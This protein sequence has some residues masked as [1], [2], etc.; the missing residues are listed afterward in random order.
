MQLEHPVPSLDP[1]VKLP[2][3]A[4]FPS[5]EI[6]TKSITSELPE[7]VVP[8]AQHERTGEATLPFL[9][10]ASIVKSP[11]STAFPFCAMVT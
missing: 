5:V 2:K 8:P 7:G 3:S 1:C 10:Y 6:V 11:K 4:A 9:A